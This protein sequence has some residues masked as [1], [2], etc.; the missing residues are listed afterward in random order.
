MDEIDQQILYLLQEDARNNTNAALSERVGVSPSTV[1]KRIKGMEADGVITG[2]HP[3]IDYDR[4]GYPLRVLFVCTAPITERSSLLE[5]AAGLTGV[6]SI[7][8]LMTGGDNLHVEV[9]GRD[10]GDITRLAT[11]IH[12]LGISINEEILVKTERVQP[13]SVLDRQPAHRD[14]T[15]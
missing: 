7:R 8:E 13:T 15:H 4:A 11:A 14:G 1:G 5:A 9:V 10:T 6:V 2:Y 3:A 12:D